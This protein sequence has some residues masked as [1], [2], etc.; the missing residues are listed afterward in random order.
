MKRKASP[1]RRIIRIRIE[2][3]V[4]MWLDKVAIMAGVSREAVCQ[5]LLAQFAVR[6]REREAP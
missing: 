2:K 1:R 4:L 6:E 5:V 3:P